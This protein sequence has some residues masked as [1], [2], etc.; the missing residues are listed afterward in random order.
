MKLTNKDMSVLI[1][2]LLGDGYIDDKGR[3]GIEHGEKQKD[4]CIFKAKLLHSVCGGK[5]IIVHEYIRNHNESKDGRKY[6]DDTFVTYSFKKQSKNFIPIRQMLYG[7][8]RRKHITEEIL[9]YLSIESIALWWM[10]DGNLSKKY[11]YPNGKQVHCGYSLNLYTYTSYEENELIQK[12]FL[13]K[14]DIKWN[15]IPAKE[16]KD[17][18]VKR[19]CLRCGTIEG[20]KFLSLIRDYINDKVPSMSY[21]VLDI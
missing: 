1:G 4:Y 16:D 8:D 13:S 11:T 21:K 6:K 19:Y 14:F 17:K 5:D 12:Y 3:I 2:L 15:I 18:E 9:N 10:D 7:E 20:R